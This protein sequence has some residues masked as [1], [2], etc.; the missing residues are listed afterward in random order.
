MFTAPLGGL[1][2]PSNT[3]ADLRSVLD[4]AGFEWVTSH[5][6]RKTAA[7]LL[8]QA[9]LTV[10]AIA[11]QLG[12]ADVTTTQNHYF[13]RRMITTRAAEVLEVIGSSPKTASEKGG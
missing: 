8:E 2:D 3:Q 4:A 12:H 1:R 7:T 10:R 6:F 5:T 13:G 11:D 9:G